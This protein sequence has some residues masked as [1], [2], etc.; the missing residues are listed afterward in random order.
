MKKLNKVNTV[1][2]VLSLLINTICMILT[3][4]GKYNSNVLVCLTMY[5]IVFIPRIIRSVL[6]ENVS[7]FIELIFLVFI[8]IAQLLGSI[9]H[10]YSIIH[11]FDSFVHYISGILTAFLGILILNEFKMYDKKNIFF[12]ILYMVAITLMVASLWEIFEFTSDNIFG[13]N[14][15]KLETGVYDTMKDIICALLGSVLVIVYYIYEVK[16][17]KKLIDK[18]IKN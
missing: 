8:F 14:A 16:C 5:G 10:F 15:Q 6:K 3:L 13:Y 7:D 9:M 12:N 1:V 11:W 18:L 17:N 2:I 4:F